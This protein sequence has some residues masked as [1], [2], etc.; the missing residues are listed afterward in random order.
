ML[1]SVSLF[2][3]MEVLDTDISQEDKVLVLNGLIT[4]DSLIKSNISTSIHSL[5][6]DAYIKFINDAEVKLFEDGEF[7]EIMQKD[8]FGYYVSTIHPDLNKSYSISAKSG[9]YPEVS[10]TATMPDSVAIDDI[11]INIAIDSTTESWYN[12]QTGQY[13]DTTLYSISGD[14]TVFVSFTDPNEANYYLLSFSIVQPIYVYDQYGNEFI[15]GYYETP[16]WYQLDGTSENIQYFSVSNIMAGFVFN[17]NFFSGATKNIKTTINTWSLYDPY[18]GEMPQSP[19][20]VHLYTLSKELYDYI[21]SYN[22]YQEVIGNPFSEPV[23]ILSNVQNGYGL[24]SGFNVTTD[25]VSLGN[26]SFTK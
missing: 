17:D 19:L 6:G 26:F 10:A 18:Y 11:Q 7:V 4:P 14:G 8:T 22:K 5:D 25:S 12:P 24:F 13:F 23:N 20:Y 1:L 15:S 16:I 2:S 21:I 9:N 3:C